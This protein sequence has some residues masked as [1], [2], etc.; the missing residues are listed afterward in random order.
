MKFVFAMVLA[1]AS[2]SPVLAQIGPD[3]IQTMP[4]IPST[5]IISTS[6]PP[7][8]PIKPKNEAFGITTFGITFC[9]LFFLSIFC[10]AIFFAF[11]YLKQR[12]IERT[13]ED[14]IPLSPY[15]T[16]NSTV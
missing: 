6:L 1:I 12:N 9:V 3:E 4:P 16:L 7:P 2:T 5:Q 15:Q 8:I 10:A 11:R 13:A 14:N